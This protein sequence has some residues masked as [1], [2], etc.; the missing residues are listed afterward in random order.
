MGIGHER[1]ENG[2]SVMGGIPVEVTQE[3][4]VV[5]RCSRAAIGTPFY[6]PHTTRRKTVSV[7]YPTPTGG[8]ISHLVVE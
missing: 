6:S 7:F 3:A 4:G 5:P 8:L 2:G 1:F